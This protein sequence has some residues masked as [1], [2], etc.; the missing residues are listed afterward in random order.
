[1]PDTTVLKSETVG[2]IRTTVNMTVLGAIIALVAKFT[3]WDLEVDDLLP[4]VPI[5]IPVVAAFYRLSLYLAHK[6]E[7]LG[8]LLYGINAP[9]TY[10]PPA[11]PVDNAVILPPE[12]DAGQAPG[13]LIWTVVGVLAVIALCIWIF[14]R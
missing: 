11:P 7:W 6:I 8:V 1:M 14:G 12:G 4:F 13:G 3:D 2:T 5:L 10:T 9:P